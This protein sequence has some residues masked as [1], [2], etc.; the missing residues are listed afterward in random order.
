MEVGSQVPCKTCGKDFKRHGNRRNC[1]DCVHPSYRARGDALKVFDTCKCGAQF[2]RRKNGSKQ[3][4]CSDECRKKYYWRSP[5]SEEQKAKISA[6]KKGKPT[7]LR[8]YKQTDE[9]LIKRLGTG[10]IRASKEELSLVPVLTKLGYRHTGEGSFWRRWPD[11]TLHNPDFV[12][13][14]DKKIVEYFGSYWHDRSEEAH[15]IEQWAALGYEC[16]VIWDTERATVL[17]GFPSAL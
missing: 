2:S 8:G 1:N 10:A 6:A 5:T 4:Y 11:G 15:A 13:E 7:K 14:T 3:T 17:S 16:R 9:H 12:N